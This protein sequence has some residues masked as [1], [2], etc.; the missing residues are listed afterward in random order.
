MEEIVAIPACFTNNHAPDQGISFVPYL[1]ATPANRGRVSLTRHMISLITEGE[2]IMH[3]ENQ[4]LHLTPKRI[5]LFLREGGGYG[6][7]GT[8]CWRYDAHASGKQHVPDFSLD[9]FLFA[10]CVTSACLCVCV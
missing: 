6:R 3:V 10:Y 8:L 9:E 2:K 1:S 5:L 4:T 7:A